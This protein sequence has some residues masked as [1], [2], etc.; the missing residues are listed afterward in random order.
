MVRCCM[1]HHVKENL[2]LPQQQANQVL[3]DVI[4]P[5]SYKRVEKEKGFSSFT[6]VY[7]CWND[8]EY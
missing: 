6:G 3:Q 5:M 7:F 1:C 2:S 8:V 4:K